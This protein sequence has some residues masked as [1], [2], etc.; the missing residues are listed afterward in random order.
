MFFIQKTSTNVQISSSTQTEHTHDAAPFLCAMLLYQSFTN[1]NDQPI[2]F[3]ATNMDIL[4]RKYRQQFALLRTTT[5]HP[6]TASAIPW[7]DLPDRF[8]EYDRMN[9]RIYHTVCC[10]ERLQSELNSILNLHSMTLN[11]MHFKSNLVPRIL[12]SHRQRCVTC[13]EP[14]SI[15]SRS[16]GCVAIEYDAK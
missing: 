16:K 4:I 10:S 2:D 14:I 3:L 1:K 8:T 6:I 7:Y 12:E 15:K 5:K 11:S 13:D 9:V